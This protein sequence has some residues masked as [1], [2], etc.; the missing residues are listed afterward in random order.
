MI[1]PDSVADPL[2]YPGR[3]PAGSGL[4]VAG[5]F[6]PVADRQQL[7]DALAA[8]GVSPMTSRQPVL[9][10]GAN[11]S[12]ERLAAKLGP[13]AIVPMTSAIVTDVAVG[14]SA[15]VSPGRYVPVAPISAP[16]EQH[17]LV[18][19]WLDAAQLAAVDRT[20]PNYRRVPLAAPVT[21]PLV[22]GTVDCHVYAS[23]WGCL[24]D[25]GE[26]RRLGDQRRLVSDLLARSAEL[27]ALFGRTPEE[28]VHAAGD[29]VRRERAR[30]IMVAAGWVRPQPEFDS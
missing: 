7:A 25:D 21:V 12:P 6:E 8:A 2:G 15:H 19:I 1:R 29:P 16:G 3:S 20:E 4:L 18:M 28:F 17:R 23:R 11:G 13:S 5:R 27:R 10:V 14:V 26:P 22:G 9:A 30:E 24:L